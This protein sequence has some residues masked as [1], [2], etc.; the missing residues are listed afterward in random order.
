MTQQRTNDKAPDR[1]N[2]ADRPARVKMNSGNKLSAPKREGYQ[3]YWSITG[4]DHPGKLEEMQAA[5]WEIVKREDGS[6]ETRNAGNGNTHVLMEIEQNLY[7]ED[8]AD[9][10]KRA[11]DSSQKNMQALGEEEYVPMNRNNV[12]EREII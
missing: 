10:Q 8:I 9:Q 12:V 4:P 1:T 7:D 6:Q 11:L 5:W 2:K 3:R